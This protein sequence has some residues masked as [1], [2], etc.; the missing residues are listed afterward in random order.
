MM[1]YKNHIW[2]SSLL[3]DSRI[4][5]G[6]STREGGVSTLPYLKSMNCGF[7]RG[8]DDE[9]VKKNIKILCGLAGCPEN[10]VCTPQIHSTEIRT[11]TPEN[12]G[13]GIDREVPFPCDGFVTECS[14]ITLLVRV[15]DCAPVL[16][17]GKK[18]DGSPVVGAVH[19]GWR[20]SAGGIAPRAVE[21][22]KG[23]GAVDFC[24]AI[25]ACV[26][27]CCYKVGEDMRD[28]VRSLRGTEFTERHIVSRNGSLY[29]DIAG[30]NRELLEEAG[31]DSECID[32][33]PECTACNPGRYH[34][35][36]VTGEKRGTMGAVISIGGR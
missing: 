30:M 1:Y 31:I 22:M 17:F 4:R 27:S 33:C 20:G 13:E 7:F 16:I 12:G 5:H 26:H 35:H 25:G 36:R 28:T 2:R 6:F 23:L 29:A 11:V 3:K 8:D 9:T 14:G 32:A 10:T 21:I 24:A 19:A 18:A 15:A 34:S